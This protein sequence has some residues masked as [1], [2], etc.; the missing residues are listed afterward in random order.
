M[1]R[2]CLA[3]LEAMGEDGTEAK[4]LANFLKRDK[5]AV[6]KAL[7]AMAARGTARR[8]EGDGKAPRWFAANARV[9][10]ERGGDDAERAAGE[11][12]GGRGDGGRGDERGRRRRG[13]ERSR[14][15]VEDEARDG[16]KVEG[17]DA[18]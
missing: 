2:E 8:E 1:K 17:F 10:A 12:D 9:G 13:G 6:N 4:A 3:A 16:A 11:L 7:Y 15:A 14:G 5:A 18:R